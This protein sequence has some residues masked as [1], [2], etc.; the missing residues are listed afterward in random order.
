MDLT[1]HNT[2][3]SHHTVVHPNITPLSVK[4]TYQTHPIGHI[5]AYRFDTAAMRARGGP[6]QFWLE[7]REFDAAHEGTK[8]EKIENFLANE[9]IVWEKRGR[10]EG[11]EVVLF[12]DEVVLER[13]WRG[14]GLVG[15]R[16]V[17]KLVDRQLAVS[18]CTLDGSS[19][20]AFGHEMIVMLQAG[21][22]SGEVGGDDEA[23]EEAGEKLT[24]Y[25]KRM[26]FEEWSL[27]DTAWLC[28]AG[29][30]VKSVLHGDGNEDVRS[31]S[32]VAHSDEV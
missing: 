9:A 16:A 24:Q 25:W 23:G 30:E 10:V 3:T 7:C 11:V 18:R 6:A 14:K 32:T 5:K 28:V 29:D 22:V 31:S 19:S 21:A 20:E 12:V 27:S 8:A 15:L 2:N 17:A 26:G 13:E 4:T 1:T